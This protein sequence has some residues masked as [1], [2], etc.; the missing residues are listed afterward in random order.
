[1]KKAYLTIRTWVGSSVGH[2]QHYYGRLR[3]GKEEIDVE[4][5]MNEE[6]AA[7][8][9]DHD[10]TYEPGSTTSRFFSEEHLRE[11][12]TKLAQEQGV[13]LL[14]EG[15]HCVCDPQPVLIGPEPLKT[16]LN[17]LNDRAEANDFWEGDEP[18]MKIIYREWQAALKKAGV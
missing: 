17:A 9:S 2:A 3:I 8:L 16:E 1:M 14:F 12:A 5:A 11:V 13:E 4:Y 10:F 7:K 18:M 15:E 6:Q